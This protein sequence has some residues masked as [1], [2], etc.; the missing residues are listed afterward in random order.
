MKNYEICFSVLLFSA[1][2]STVDGITGF[3]KWKHPSTGKAN[4]VAGSAYALLRD[5]G[6]VRF[7]SAGKVGLNSA[8]KVSGFI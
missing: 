1:G 5:S 2:C 4:L 6:K 7:C 8:E 3:Q